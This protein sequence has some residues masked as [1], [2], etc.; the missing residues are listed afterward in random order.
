[1]CGVVK[2]GRGT[3]AVEF[4]CLRGKLFEG[5][6]VRTGLSGADWL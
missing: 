6:L 2:V 5:C 4:A 3:A 1:V